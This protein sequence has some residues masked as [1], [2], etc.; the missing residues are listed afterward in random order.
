[1]QEKLL[2]VEGLSK[3]Y[4]VRR[5][6]LG[7]E[8]SVVK[9]VDGVTLSLSKGETLGLVGESG[10]GKTTLARLLLRLE[11]PT[12]GKVLYKGRDVFSLR[13]EELQRYR[14]EVQMIFQDP[15][16]SL[17]PRMRVRDIIGEPLEIHGIVDED[18][19]FERV[20]ELL[21]EVGLSREDAEKYPHEFSG[22]Q[23]QRIGIARALAL[24]PSLI[25]ADEPVSALDISIQA[26][27][28][29]LLRDLQEE[30]G[31][32]YLFIAHNMAV[33]RQVS[34]RVA[35]MKAGRIVEEGSVDRIFKSPEHPYTR[36]LLQAVPSSSPRLRRF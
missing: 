23:R 27:I 30:H 8:V 11:E 19:R 28:L 36:E 25:V 20:V 17:D 26:Q 16:S 21:L 4:P 1:L 33:V 9:A 10:C 22:G 15:Q 12:E 34:D 29:G 35:V 13:E 5:G 32:S 14:R 31:L 24:K 7:R 3:H 2:E 6:L 18:E